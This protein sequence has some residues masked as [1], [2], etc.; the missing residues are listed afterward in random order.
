MKK[1]H[2]D[3]L[4]GNWVFLLILILSIGFVLLGVIKPFQF[5]NPK[6]YNYISGTGF[7]LQTFFW[8]KTFW[9]RNYVSW[10][11][12]GTLIRINSLLGKSI[13]FK[14]VKNVDLQESVLSITKTGDEN[15]QF[16]LSEFQ[17][18]DIERLHEILM[19]HTRATA[20]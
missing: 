11:K 12:V 2:F 15:I 13:T 9:F 10:N 8:S 5:E 17:K 16:D 6:V 20:I 14:D 4:N 1:I 3:Q 7:L 18:A 19:S